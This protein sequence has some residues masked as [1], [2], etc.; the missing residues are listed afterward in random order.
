MSYYSLA[1]GN[2]AKYQRYGGGRIGSF[3]LEIWIWSSITFRGVYI[4][5]RLLAQPWVGSLQRPCSK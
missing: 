3:F 4:K 2:Y 1:K 5:Q